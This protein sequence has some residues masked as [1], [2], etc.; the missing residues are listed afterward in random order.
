MNN[1]VEISE[2]DE[3][4]NQSDRLTLKLKE[5]QLKII[6]HADK[7]E[8]ATIIIN[9]LNEVLTTKCGILGDRVGSGKSFMILGLIGNNQ[10]VKKKEQ[11][12]RPTKSSML[13]VYY[14][15]DLNT[16]FEKRANI[17]VVPHNIFI[18]WKKYIEHHTN[19]DTKFINRRSMIS[20]YDYYDKDIILVSSTMYKD[21]ITNIIVNGF[22]FQR[23]IFDEADTIELLRCQSINANF[24]WFIS[25]SIGN[26]VYPNGYFVNEQITYNY[27][28]TH[29]LGSNSYHYNER[30]LVNSG[31]QHTGFI[32][33]TFNSLY[34]SLYQRYIF[35]KCNDELI[36]NSM[37]LIE[38]IEVIIYC[39]NTHILNI[40]NGIV[41]TNIQNMIYANDIQGAIRELCIEETNETNIIKL[42]ANNLYT[43]L[44]N[45][46]IEYDMKSQFTYRSDTL[47]NEALEKVQKYINELN[48]KI[49]NIKDR[50]STSNIDPITY[51]EINNPVIVK[52]C[53]HTFDFVS[54]TTWLSNKINAKCP[55]CRAI[56]TINDL[57]SINNNFNEESN[58]DEVPVEF[59][60]N[61]Q[62][63][64]VN[65]EYLL[66]NYIDKNAKILIF[67]EF[68]ES[69]IKT[70][71][72][73]NNR[74]IKYKQIKGCAVTVNN[75]TTKYRNSDLNVL[76]LNARHCA[77]G[78]NLE[79]T[80]DIIIYHKMLPE[81]EQQI[82]GRAQRI[83]RTTQLKVWKLHYNSE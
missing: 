40:L 39:K 5:H 15:E 50:I 30:I 22:Y 38:P 34:R 8:S 3:N 21:F 14:N 57:V 55:I 4:A 12:S 58:N 17:I 9:E 33:N 32:K 1:I 70:T 72:I 29:L 6:H 36:K 11:M 46:Q 24:Y 62:D 78:L 19:F 67:S 81:L 16:D 23:L 41:N 68:D 26:L 65:F 44:N 53:Q 49:N 27:P 25:S 42:V 75:I 20:P 37:Q 66:D 13:S 45:K 64:D 59:Y 43:E 28:S 10:F 76:H 73:L 80:T 48:T 31:I 51:E 69:F 63:K 77:T 74:S 79:N 47:R 61:E 52:C 60:S 82:I 18:Q 7:L 54:I 71:S 2:T 35:L 56:I 83:G